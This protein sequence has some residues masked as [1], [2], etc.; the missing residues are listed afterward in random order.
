MFARQSCCITKLQ[1]ICQVGVNFPQGIIIK[2]QK[3]DKREAGLWVKT[4]T[5]RALDHFDDFYGTFY[6]NLWQSTRLAMLSAP[7]HCALVNYYADYEKTIKNLKDMGCIEIQEFYEESRSKK[8]KKE[9]NP[10]K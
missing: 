9:T 10:S 8:N 2:R 7:K 1:K 5:D 6:G 3:F 4:N